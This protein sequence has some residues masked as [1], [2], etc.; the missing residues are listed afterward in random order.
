MEPRYFLDTNV[1]SFILD[2]E[3]WERSPS[4]LMG[5][6]PE[7]V[8]VWRL[9]QKRI[10]DVPV[11]NEELSRSVSAYTWVK[12]RMK[13]NASSSSPQLSKKSWLVH[14]RYVFFFFFFEIATY[15]ELLCSCIYAVSLLERCG[16]PRDGRGV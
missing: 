4:T 15:L 11:H 2:G 5:A 13:T 1:A 8:A 14:H 12:K 16:K 9:A 6:R 7:L 3:L 10:E